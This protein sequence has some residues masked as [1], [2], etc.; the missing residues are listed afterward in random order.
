M[1]M[2]GTPINLASI[3]S[4]VKRNLQADNNEEGVLTRVVLFPF[5]LIGQVI[6]ALAPVA[7][8]ILTVF[9]LVVG[10]VL[11]F[12][13]LLSIAVVMIAFLAISGVVDWS[14]VMYTDSFPVQQAM[15]DLPK[16]S[17]YSFALA[18]L[19]PLVLIL[20]LSV[21]LLFIQLKVPAGLVV[22]LVVLWV[23][24]IV[25]ASV[26]GVALANSLK[27][28]AEVSK[29]NYLPNPSGPIAI[30]MGLTDKN[31][32]WSAIDLKVAHWNGDS[33]KIERIYEANGPTLLKAERYAT[34]VT[35]NVK[36]EG[37][38]LI[39]DG[40]FELP[41]DLPAR[42]QKVT[43]KVYLPTGTTFTIDPN[44]ASNW[45]NMDFNHGDRGTLMRGAKFTFDGDT[46][47]IDAIGSQ[48]KGKRRI[49]PDGE[50]HYRLRVMVDGENLI[51]LDLD[52]KVEEDED[53]D[54]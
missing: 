33:I 43:V 1:K 22:S 5:R 7:A 13:M 39:I 51:N 40:R 31:Y 20:L 17:L 28:E 27:E 30:R 6:K 4:T 52:E 18:A 37:N 50:N 8:A 36:L 24:S 46:L 9:R 35:H 53:S 38:E 19:M 15:Y 34:G 48:V 12:S 25:F 14:T 21:K 49:T 26:G 32:N 2:E 16:F 3:E 47:S 44:F 23:I 10:S 41:A 11:F 45:E 42:D 54:Y 29:V